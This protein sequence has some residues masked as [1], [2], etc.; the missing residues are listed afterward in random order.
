MFYLRTILTSYACSIATDSFPNSAQSALL[1]RAHDRPQPSWATT[2]TLLLA[3]T[4]LLFALSTSDTAQ[5]LSTLEGYSSGLGV[6]QTS[7]YTRLST[8]DTT[9]CFRP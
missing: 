2:T 7:R 8:L 9:G 5:D 3:C 1:G 4:P 6:G